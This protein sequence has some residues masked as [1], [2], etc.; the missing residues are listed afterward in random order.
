[1]FHNHHPLT[2]ILYVSTGV[3]RN[4]WKTKNKEE[5]D[6]VIDACGGN[7]CILVTLK[8]SWHLLPWLYFNVLSTMT[9]VVGALG[10]IGGG[11]AYGACCV[12]LVETFMKTIGRVYMALMPSRL[13]IKNWR[14]CM[15]ALQGGEKVLEQEK[16]SSF[17]VALW[18]AMVLAMVTVAVRLQTILPIE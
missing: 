16:L 11:V 17:G 1:M 7:A 6:E 10:F 15:H 5:Y 8:V 18:A 3:A 9:I 14:W 12:W 4:A 13:G 2:I